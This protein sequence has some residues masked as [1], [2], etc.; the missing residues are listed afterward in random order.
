MR[1]FSVQS[2]IVI[3]IVALLLEGSSRASTE[4][5]RVGTAWWIKHISIMN[6]GTIHLNPELASL[7]GFTK[8]NYLLLRKG[9]GLILLI[10]AAR[11]VDTHNLLTVIYRLFLGCSRWIRHL[12]GAYDWRGAGE[13]R[14]FYLLLDDRLIHHTVLDQQYLILELSFHFIAHYLR[15][16][17]NF[18]RSTS[19]TCWSNPVRRRLRLVRC[20]IR[21][22]CLG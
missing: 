18:S 3:I 21:G 6:R 22:C 1:R 4:G 10:S 5:V 2:S 14:P 15:S 11:L 17:C 12:L 7:E 13:G 9:Q 8:F 19:T 16:G 20:C